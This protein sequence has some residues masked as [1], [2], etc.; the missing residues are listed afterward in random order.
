MAE[1]TMAMPTQIP[2][3]GDTQKENNIRCLTTIGHF[4]FE[5]LPNQLVSRSIRQGFTFNILCVGETG[6]GKS[7]LID[8][9]FN[10]NLKDNKSSHFYSNVGLQIQT[11]ELQE[12]NVQLKLT[13]VETVGYGDQIDKEA[14]YQPIVDYIDAQFEAYLQEELKIKRS[15]FEYHDSRVH[16]CLYFI[17]PTGHS[18]KSLDLL[19]MKNLDSKVNII[20]LIA[21]ADT[22][23]KNDLQTFKN[24]I[25]SELISNGI[26]IY[27][28]PTD[29]ETAAQANSSVSGLLPFAVVGS[30]D[31]VKVGKRMVRGRHYPWGVLQVENENHCD[32]VKLR[33]MLL[34]TNMENLK[35]KTHTQHYECYRYQKLQKMGFTDVGPNNQPVSFQEIFEAKRQEFYD[36]CQREEEELKQRFMQRVKEKEATFKEAEKELQDKFEHLKMIQ[37]EEIRKLEEEKKQLE[38]EI[39]DFYKMKAASEALQTQLSTDTK[40]D[41]HRK[42]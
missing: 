16:V 24:K 14:S 23:S 17:S 6:I 26:Q 37:Q 12:S 13:V 38:G 32:F 21:K 3:D 30:T 22:I 11:Y 1:R 33:D 2:A 29:E 28:L 42:K 20:P 5:C 19:T 10:T 41:K 36:Q 8:T 15:L 4:G 34:C 9:L 7:T 27:Q 39:I 25:M 18:L 40:K 31:E 35:E